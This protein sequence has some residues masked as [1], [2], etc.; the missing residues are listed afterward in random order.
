M[1]S[2]FVKHSPTK[3]NMIGTDISKMVENI[4]R[5]IVADFL[6]LMDLN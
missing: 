4:E 1:N 5:L 3:T 6:K 2:N